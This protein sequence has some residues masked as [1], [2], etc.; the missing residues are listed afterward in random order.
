M[1]ILSRI[2][3]LC[4]T[5]PPRDP[6]CWRYEN[7]LVEISLAAAHELSIPG[8]A[9]RLEGRG[10]PMRV[11]VFL[12][13]G[14]RFFAFHNRCTHAGR[15]LDPLPGLDRVQCCSVGKTTFDLDGRA[16]S[17]SGKKNATKLSTTQRDGKLFVDL[18]KD[19]RG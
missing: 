1:G 7:G 6:N 5:K 12:G 15:R 2:L 17:G 14:G 8:G 19:H 18:G 16:L 10:L 9:I 11:L 3:G 13:K 4:Q